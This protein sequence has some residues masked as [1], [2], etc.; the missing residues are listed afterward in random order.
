VE[1]DPEKLAK[2]RWTPE[3]HE[4]NQRIRA[5]LIDRYQVVPADTWRPD[6]G[7]YPYY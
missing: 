3:K 2:Y 4:E 1:L 6:L 7:S 5:E